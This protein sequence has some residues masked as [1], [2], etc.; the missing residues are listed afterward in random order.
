ME[1]GF[2]TVDRAVASDTRELGFESK[3]MGIV[4]D[5]QIKTTILKR[6][7]FSKINLGRDMRDECNKHSMIVNYT[8]T[9][10]I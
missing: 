9:V 7:H 4:N 3:L 10:T 6:G 1:G 8:A 5:L 2:G